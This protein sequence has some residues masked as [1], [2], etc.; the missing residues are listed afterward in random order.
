MNYLK[1][2]IMEYKDVIAWTYKDLKGIPLELAQCHI[3]L[4]TS[5]PPAHQTKYKMNPNYRY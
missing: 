2:L 5:I 3:E 1:K 4:D